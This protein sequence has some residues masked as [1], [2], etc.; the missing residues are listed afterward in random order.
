MKS[1]V[2]FDLGTPNFVICLFRTL[3]EYFNVKQ[4]RDERLSKNKY[5]LNKIERE[6]ENKAPSTEI[7]K[8]LCVPGCHSTELCARRPLLVPPSISKSFEVYLFSR[9]VAVKPRK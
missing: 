6:R 5:V 7:L 4:L 3:R 2:A 1:H 9:S 8:T